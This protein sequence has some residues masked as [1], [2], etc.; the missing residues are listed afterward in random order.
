MANTFRRMFWDI[1]TSPNIVTS[2]RIGY[3][4]Q[5]SADNI[6][7]ERAIICICWKWE[8]E[9][10][11]YSLTWDKNQCDKTLL[12]KFVKE[13]NKADEAIGQNSDK[14]DERWFRTRCIFHDI[15]TFPKY[16]SVDTLKMAKKGFYFN[17]NR[18]DY[19]GKFLGCGQK[20]KTEFDLWKR[21]CLENDKDA[22]KFMV[23]Y[24]KQDVN[25]LEQV[26]HKLE[27]YSEPKT[28]LGVALGG[29]RWDCPKCAS[30]KVF[31]NKTRISAAGIEKKQMNCKKC[32]FTYTISGNVFRNYQEHRL[33]E[34]RKKHNL[35]INK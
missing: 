23:E 21:I 30:D 14:F 5:I 29:E 6:I 22:L 16:K 27:K 20:I 11:V 34:E 12:E 4:L 24:C 32:G 35:K 3:K 2:W 10:E 9:E 7:K 33:K 31:V 8:G 26:Y 13:I 19:M 25:L 18:L 28:H 1:E 17:S 15:P